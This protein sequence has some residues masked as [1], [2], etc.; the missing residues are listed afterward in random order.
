MYS[1]PAA[2]AAI[3]APGGALLNRQR[4][5][6]AALPTSELSSPVEVTVSCVFTIVILTLPG[7]AHPPGPEGCDAAA[8]PCPGHD[9]FGKVDGLAL[10]HTVQVPSQARLFNEYSS[11]ISVLLRQTAAGITTNNTNPSPTRS[12]ARL[13]F[14]VS[15]RHALLEVCRLRSESGRAAVGACCSRATVAAADAPTA[16]AETGAWGLASD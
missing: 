15:L 16:G 8:G 7:P 14:C 10:C 5:N 4:V 1:I 11:A 9:R 2:V 3:A 6:H 13:G 12:P